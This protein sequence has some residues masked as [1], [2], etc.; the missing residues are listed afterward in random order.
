MRGHQ[1][2][3]ISTEDGQVHQLPTLMCGPEVI[4]GFTTRFLDAERLVVAGV[5]AVIYDVTRRRS[6]DLLSTG[7]ADPVEACTILPD[8]GIALGH[9]SGRIHVWA[10]PEVPRWSE[11]QARA[12]QRSYPPPQER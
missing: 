8:G 4:A 2:V 5:G 6:I 7:G 10:G 12:G 9:N 1:P 11:E 3:L